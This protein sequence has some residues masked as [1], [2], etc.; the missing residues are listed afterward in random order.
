MPVLVIPSPLGIGGSSLISCKGGRFG[1]IKTAFAPLVGSPRRLTFQYEANI[2]TEADIWSL[3]SC[4]YCSGVASCEAEARDKIEDGS[5][6]C[7]EAE[8]MLTPL[9]PIVISANR[10]DSFTWQLTQ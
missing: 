4:P 7:E 5:G 6:D 8:A 2:G 1:G 3:V 10:G 9:M